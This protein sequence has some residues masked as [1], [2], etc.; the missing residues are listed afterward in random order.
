MDSAFKRFLRHF[1]PKH[2]PQAERIFVGAFGKHPGWDDHIDDIGLETD[3]L[4]EAKRK[5]YI[6]GIGGNVDS[7]RW[8]K[9]KNDCLPEGFNREIFWYMDGHLIAGRMWPSQD[10]KGRKSYP[11]VVC[12]QCSKLPMRWI[13]D[14]IPPQLE[15]IK[16]MCTTTNSAHDVRITIQ[17]SK[18][19]LRR[20]AKQC[21]NSSDSLTMYPNAL[22]ELTE[23]PAM[24]PDR[25]GL[26]RVLYHID[27]EVGLFQPK[28]TK[29]ELPGTT[30]L[31]LPVC[32][33][34]MPDDIFLWSSFFLNTFGLT[35]SILVLAPL[36]QNWIDVIVGG[37]TEL[38]LFCLRA[39]PGVIPL[40]SN[41][42]YSVGPEFI[43]RV[44]GLIHESQK[45]IFRRK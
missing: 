41:I 7:G 26:F 15:K 1:S 22:A 20:L 35:M 45:N 11:F 40:T 5:L 27:R 12:I 23:H 43:E 34:T 21:K 19:E 17:S 10:G 13:L 42:P 37:S 29:C 9:L 28:I 36:A 44:N 8:D 4:I 25:E 18:Q 32:S 38:Q 31:R 6:K 39:S 3:F 24:G 30:L 33:N 16:R 14:N 2:D